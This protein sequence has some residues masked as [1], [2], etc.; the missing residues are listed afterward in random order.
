ML[1]FPI[2]CSVPGNT[3]FR[4]YMVAVHV[5]NKNGNGVSRLSIQHLG[6]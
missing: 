4:F 6:S 2:V 3:R 1:N 5:I